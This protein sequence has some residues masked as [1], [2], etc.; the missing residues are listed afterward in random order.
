M[1]GDGYKPCGDAASTAAGAD[2]VAAKTKIWDKRLNADYKALQ[3]TIGQPQQEPLRTAQRLW[4]QYRDANCGF[5]G[6]QEGSIAQLQ[7]A[8][9]LRAMTQDRA[10]E[11]E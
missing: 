3:G 2:C 4:V 7:Q 1:F 5:Y 9:C 11:F 10:L 6:K 8:E